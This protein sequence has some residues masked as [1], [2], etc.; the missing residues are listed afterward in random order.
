MN[1]YELERIGS[2]VVGLFCSGDYQTIG[3]LF[4]YSLAFN[5]E[6]VEAISSDFENAVREVSG[7]LES[8]T[9][10]VRVSSFGDN[11]VGLRHL[12]ECDI[13]FSNQSGILIELVYRV[14]GKVILEDI[15]SYKRNFNA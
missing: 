5:R 15:T 10:E 12:V 4:G 9:Y 2:Q 11:S 3:R 1:Q 6:A 7:N 14:A 13:I 8:S